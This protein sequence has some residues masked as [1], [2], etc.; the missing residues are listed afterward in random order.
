[1]TELCDIAA[2]YGTDKCPQIKHPFTEFYYEMLKDK[3]ESTRKVVEIGIGMMPPLYIRGASLYMWRAFF[4]NALV[5]GAD[6]DPSLLFNC[7]RIK[8]LYCDQNNRGDLIRLLE[9]TGTDIDL[10]VEDGTHLPDDQIF[11]AR[12]VVPMLDASTVYVIED[13]RHYEVIIDAL[14]EFDCTPI[15]KRHRSWKD[16]CLVVVRRKT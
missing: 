1:M 16:D 3:R 7:D 13:A 15:R 12:I 8:T 5:Y 10:F 11:T 2:M 4:P 6:I 14:S 9:S